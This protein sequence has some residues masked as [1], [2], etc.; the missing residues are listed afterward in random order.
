MKQ[1]S[2]LERAALVAWICMLLGGCLSMEFGYPVANRALAGMV[3]GQT[4]HA[5][6]LLAL[7][8][9]RGVGALRVAQYERPRDALYYEYLKASGSQVEVEIL[10]VLMQDQRFDGYMWF[11]SSARVKRE[12][13]VP[14]LTPPAQVEM[15][16]FPSA[17]PLEGQFVRGLTDR[18]EILATLGPPSGYGGAMLPPEHQPLDILYYEC[19]KAGDM[20]VAGN[21]MLIQMEQRMLVVMLDR[22]VFSGFMWTVNAGTPSARTDP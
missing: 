4:T 1:F 21:E 13:G 15:G 2:R 17:Q 20:S 12:G 11:G 18:K 6:I 19:V 16:R 8:E 9:P 5:E 14:G 3:P 22:D 10:I 7:G